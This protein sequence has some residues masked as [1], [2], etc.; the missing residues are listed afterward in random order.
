MKVWSASK[1]PTIPQGPPFCSTLAMRTIRHPA[2]DVVLALQTD[3]RWT[4]AD[5]ISVSDLRLGAHI[6]LNGIHEVRP[7]QPP[8]RTSRSCSISYGCIGPAST[9]LPSGLTWHQMNGKAQRALSGSWTLR[10]PLVAL[11]L[12][13]PSR[14]QDDPFHLSAMLR[15]YGNAFTLCADVPVTCASVH[16][17][18]PSTQSFTFRDGTYLLHPGRTPDSSSP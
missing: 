13:S 9:A 5:A 18:L 7:R 17:S 12:F 2:Y 11:C 10:D 6:V 1:Q 4:G 15:W 8:A 16:M 14:W 3:A